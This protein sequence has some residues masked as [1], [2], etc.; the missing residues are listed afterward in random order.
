MDNGSGEAK[1]FI[2]GR[3]VTRSDAAL[4]ALVNKTDFTF[5]ENGYSVTVDALYPDGTKI[6]QKIYLTDA[7]D[8]ATANALMQTYGYN[9]DGS[10]STEN[11]SN[12]SEDNTFSNPGTALS[13]NNSYWIRHDESALLLSLEALDEN[14][15]PSNIK[16]S[17]LKHDDLP[18]LNPGMTN[19][20]K[21]PRRGY[22]FNPHGK[23]FRK[24]IDVY[25]PYDVSKIPD[26]MTEDDIKTWYYNDESGSW[27]QLE[28]VEVNKKNKEVKS[29]TNHFTDMIN[30]TLTVPD[31]PQAVN[32]NPTQIKDIKAADPGAEVNLIEPPQANNMGDARLSYPI[33]LP[34]GR[35]GMQA[36]LAL[37][38]NSSGGNG[39]LGLGWDLSM[40]SIS[41]ETRWGVPRYSTEKETETYLLSG[42]QLSPVAHRGS[43]QTRVDNRDD[44]HTR[45]EGAFQKII[46]HGTRPANYWWEVIDKNG[47]KNFYGGDGSAQIADAVIGNL[48]GIFR[49]ML[50]KTQDT[51]GNTVE[52][53]YETLC[54]TG[55]D[56]G[57]CG[58]GVSGYQHYI[59]KIKYTGHASSPA[60]YSIEFVRDSQKPGYIRDYTASNYDPTKDRRRDVQIDARGGFKQVTAERLKDIIVKYQN[61]IV[62]SYELVYI[63]GAFNKT[64]LQTIIQKGTDGTEF[65][66]HKFDYYDDIT[67]P[68]G[69]YKGFVQINN[70]NMGGD[71]YEAN[72][73][74]RSIPYTV[75][76]GS[77]GKSIGF[78][79]YGG[80]GLAVGTKNL[81][82]GVAGSSSESKSKGRSGFFDVD[83]DGLPDKV[84]ESNYRSNKTAPGALNAIAFNTDSIETVSQFHRSAESESTTYNLG[85]QAYIFGITVGGGRGTTNTNE[86]SYL[87]DI[88]GDG[89]VDVVN[90]G[91]VWFNSPT[92]DKAQFSINSFDSGTPIGNVGGSVSPD[93]IPNMDDQQARLEAENPLLDNVRRWV[94]PYTGSVKIT[95][96]VELVNFLTDPRT[97]DDTQLRE[98]RAEY[99]YAD[100]VR[101]AIQHNDQELWSSQIAADH[102]DPVPANIGSVPVNKGDE[103]FFRVGSVKDGSYD[104]VDWSPSIDYLGAA[105]PA[106]LDVN[107]LPVYSYNAASDFIYSNRELELTVPYKGTLRLAGKLNKT[108]VTTDDLTV[109]VSVISRELN[110]DYSIK[111]ES[112]SIVISKTIPW[113]STESLLLE[114]DIQVERYNGVKIHFVT[115]SPIDLTAFNWGDS[116]SGSNEPTNLPTL[117]YT[118][119]FQEEE[120]PLVPDDEDIVVPPEDEL[121]TDGDDYFDV[122]K[123]P[124]D[125]NPIKDE[126]GNDVII[127]G[128]WFSQDELYDPITGEPIMVMPVKYDA[129]IYPAN[130]LR[131]PQD[132]WVAPKDGVI[133]LTPWFSLKTY[134]TDIDDPTTSYTKARDGSVFFTIKRRNE[135]LGKHEVVIENGEVSSQQ[136]YD[137]LKA[138]EVKKGD[139]IFY[140]LNIR[141]RTFTESENNQAKLKKINTSLEQEIEYAEV[142]IH[143]ASDQAWTVP[144]TD[145]I[146][147]LSTLDAQI[148][149]DENTEIDNRYMMVIRR[150][151]TE[152]V[153][154]EIVKGTAQVN[155]SHTQNVIEGEQWYFDV[156]TV[157]PDIDVPTRV[158]EA[159]YQSDNSWTVLVNGKLSF[160][161]VLNFKNDNVPDGNVELRV[162]IQGAIA[163]SRTYRVE[164]GL[165]KDPLATPLTLNVIKNQVLE[166][167]YRTSSHA[168]SS[169]LADKGAVSIGSVDTI[170]WQVPDDNTISSIAVTPE[171]KLTG[172]GYDNGQVLF[173][174]LQGDIELASRSY[175]VTKDEISSSDTGPITIPVTKGQILNFVYQSDKLSIVQAMQASKVSVAVLTSTINVPYTINLT[176]QVVGSRFFYIAM[177]VSFDKQ[178]PEPV[179]RHFPLEDPLWG[180]SYRGWGIA[181]YNG[182]GERADKA[183]D[184]AIFKMKE[185]P[186]DYKRSDVE[187]FAWIAYPEVDK[188]RWGSVDNYWWTGPVE[189]S[190]SRKGADYIFTPKVEDYAGPEYQNGNS[191]AARPAKMSESDTSNYSIG[192]GLSFGKSKSNSNSQLDVMDMNGDRMP[193]MVGQNGTQFTW[194][195][196]TLFDYYTGIGRARTSKD[197]QQT[198]GFGIGGPSVTT[199]AESEKPPGGD[200]KKVDIVSFPISG[201]IG[202]GENENTSD[203]MDINGDGLPDRVVR[204]SK[205]LSVSLNTGYGF[206]P[207]ED[208]NGGSLHQGENDS[209][210]VGGGFSMWNGTIA[211]GLNLNEAHNFAN[212]GMMDIN[213][214]GLVD[215]VRKGSGGNLHVRQNTGNGFTNEFIW[216]GSLTAYKNILD[217]PGGS[218]RSSTPL[219]DGASGSA[220]GSLKFGFGF[221]ILLFNISF[222]FGGTYAETVSMPSI[223][224][225][226]VNGDGFVDGIRT[227]DSNVMDVALNPIQRTNM[228]RSVSRPMGATF[229]ID[230]KRVGNTYDYPQ[231]KYIMSDVKVFDGVEDKVNGESNDY[232]LTRYSY[233]DGYFDRYERDFY[234]FKTVVWQQ[235]D[236][237]GKGWSDLDALD[238][239]NIY[240]KTTQTYLNQD[241]YKKGLLDT[242][243]M[244]GRKKFEGLK[245]YTVTDNDY[246][247]KAVAGGES[248]A[249]KP[250]SLFPALVKTTKQFFEAGNIPVTNITEFIYDEL[251]GK[252]VYGNVKTFKDYGD[253]ADSNDDVIAALEYKQCDNSYIVD[254]TTSIIVVGKD[255]TWRKRTGDYNC[256]TGNL[257]DQYAWLEEGGLNA[258]TELKYDDYGNLSYVQGPANEDDERLELIFKYDEITNTH[259]REIFNKS[260]SITSTA[261]TDLKWGKPEWTEDVNGNRITY[262]YD[263]FG[264]TETIVGPYETAEEPTIKFQYKPIA[265]LSNR[266]PGTRPIAIEPHWAL[267]EHFDKNWKGHSKGNTI[268]TVLFTDGVKRVLQTKKDASVAGVDKI[269]ASGRVL[270]DG[271]GRSI[272]QY[273]PVAYAKGKNDT[274]FE[275][276]T[277]NINPT[278]ME[279]DALDRKESTTIPDGTTTSVV[280]KIAKGPNSY[281]RLLTK[282][283]DACSNEKETYR[284]VRELITAV[285]EYTDNTPSTGNDGK[286]DKSSRGSNILTTTYVYDSLKQIT[287][288][289]DTQDNYTKIEYDNLGRRTSIDNPDTGKVVT[290]YDL[291][292]N[293]TKNFTPNLNNPDK[294]ADSLFIDYDYD[295]TRLEAIKYPINSDINVNYFYGDSSHKTL[296]QAGRLIKVTHGGGSEE[297]EYGSLGETTLTRTTIKIRPPDKTYTTRFSY[298]TFGRLLVLNFPDGEELRHDYDSGGNLTYIEGQKRGGTPHVYL[299]TLLY[300]KFEQRTYLKL[301]NGVET[302]YSY[303]PDNRRLE[304]LQS[305][306]P[307]VRRANS[308]QFQN[309][310]YGYDEV[311]NI[312]SLSNDIL[313]PANKDMGGPTHQ[314]FRYDKLYRL[315]GANG[316]YTTS[317]EVNKYSLTMAYDDIHNITNKTQVHNIVSQNGGIKE[318]RGT[319]YDFTYG[320]NPSGENSYQPHAPRTIGNRVFEYDKNG[321]QTGFTSTETSDRRIITWDEE[322]RITSIADKGKT[323][324]YTYDDKGQ[325][326]TKRN[327]QGEVAYI[328]QF[329]TVRNG[330]IPSK[331]IYA[332]TSRILTKRLGGG[333]PTYS[334]S[335]D[336]PRGNPHDPNRTT[337]NSGNNTSNSQTSSINSNNEQNSN[338]STVNTTID[339]P[340]Q[341]LTNRSDRANE[342]AQNTVMNPH[343]NSTGI[344]GNSDHS[345]NGPGNNNGGGNGNS[346]NTGNAGNNGNKGGNSAWKPEEEF[347][348]YYHPDHLGS[349]SYVTDEDGLLYEHI[350]YFP[351][352]ETWVQEANNTERTPY[353]FTS[354]EFD[355]ETKLYYYGARYYDPRTSVWQSV[356]PIFDQYV[357]GI[358]GGLHAPMNLGLYGYGRQN[359]LYYRDAD[360]NLIFLAAIPFIIKAGGAALALYGSYEA[361]HTIGTAAVD[362]YTGDKSVGD[363]AKSAAIELGTNAAMTYTGT[364]VVKLA[365]KLI[366]DSVKKK[367]I[368]KVVEKVENVISDN[369]GKNYKGKQN[370]QQRLK[371]LADD[372]K[373]SSADRGWIKQEMNEVKKGK[374]GHLRNPPG[375]DLAH[376]RGRENA[377]GYGYEHTKIQNRKDHRT[378][379]KFD[380]WGRKNKERTPE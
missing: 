182:N 245:K 113:D 109:Q 56:Q 24:N 364:K 336:L 352:G 120:T 310:L 315:I 209:V 106:R 357:D 262:K 86:K 252:V 349:T 274:I 114:E 37:Q 228:L 325:R 251:A 318:Q 66:R 61:E 311:G 163:A 176:N 337:G 138:F 72:T 117:Y 293:I 354:K 187:H 41:V 85:L 250:G 299:D 155:Y 303:R 323:S 344:P 235:Y 132:A 76:G 91:Q 260:Y 156:F 281:N 372:D 241:Y 229:D 12:T 144:L 111:S 190:A 101:V 314:N 34:P 87:S 304:T 82:V 191:G 292:G 333:N 205:G 282:V 335:P 198:I 296:N 200:T 269:I 104:L 345:N 359:P 341:G 216:R 179:I 324:V 4:E 9:E 312:T 84:F 137:A 161:P 259:V 146:D 169:Y 64:L 221:N 70:V 219:T 134:F 17:S 44:F 201:S 365:D 166:F 362:L 26:G 6:S 363:V 52:Y 95:S 370:R 377:K 289:T 141:P 112:S 322:N 374:K 150:G 181:A 220:S 184:L 280:Y 208:W 234:G 78:E 48:D 340:G 83:G 81:N 16:I 39:W 272:K 236:T 358:A 194:A 110:P 330:S 115:S 50:V 265:A 38:Y 151:K 371:D 230:Y 249:G 197:D 149:D 55:L 93:V 366:P 279:Y 326:V 313:V 7:L 217:G 123:N 297:R 172:S 316:D 173:R 153:H 373:V 203:L 247:L 62:R 378:Q 283:T 291:A 77:K 90:Q 74:G 59:S 127:P 54:D 119:A 80:V 102:F 355:E 28:K 158:I 130:H 171:P 89:L 244:D 253:N 332:G 369:R 42:Q 165:V 19:V 3:E 379:H 108:R 97:K 277:D 135:L 375:K 11:S 180:E 195:D 143:Y 294:P 71:N 360:G 347:M 124:P 154:S 248:Q 79:A 147:F 246:L 75:L 57:I 121:P 69:T 242:E 327:D 30:A 240:R 145:N 51:N 5:E 275:T 321:N 309:I 142:K 170:D 258:H 278:I 196:G 199:D 356:D 118:A 302:N 202:E 88:N 45:V 231:S 288:V 22:R 328:S 254:K 188:N 105:N 257:T 125:M 185:N 8:A 300:D 255:G 160:N 295:Y 367:V 287:G 20:T 58:S 346:G 94:A 175:D 212:Y 192:F 348:Y 27:V 43:I 33:Q 129:D 116:V 29:H 319:S 122:A 207:P 23:K 183:I 380:N 25:I 167:V 60:P 266:E 162:M 100:G 284:E 177:P 140:D 107:N 98:D 343:L 353:L 214:D 225:Q 270:H 168:L 261:Y 305:K 222:S 350:E 18:P 320:Y 178:D 226:D 73:A 210:S 227:A 32:F 1:V 68:D 218:K 276:L 334:P 308:R 204:G 53:E 368:K 331:H 136:E 376:E 186:D 361:G 286:C 159:R 301:G 2:A 351:F 211:G 237:T 189:A 307:N 213:G 40:P 14:E 339:H 342:V 65:N 139:E 271:L 239:E 232:Q 306:L 267:T 290:E 238:D 99:K 317:K 223:S 329:Y 21:G 193:D 206:L 31:H 263:K 103:I 157:E 298:D 273:Y 36:Q 13:T 338:L 67:N 174:V 126:D 131:S 63:N 215:A 96:S 164:N 148:L 152:V 224:Y 268:D 10:D 285:K 92:K 256:D 46:R 15:S 35:A 49:W 133:F 264:R 233:E 128:K 243:Q 47:T